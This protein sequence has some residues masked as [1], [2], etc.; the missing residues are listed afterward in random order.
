MS[1][2]DARSEDGIRAAFDEAR[3]DLLQ[4]SAIA[5]GVLLVAHLMPKSP[6]GRPFRL[7]LTIAYFGALLQLCWALNQ[8]L[9]RYLNARFALLY[10]GAPIM[11]QRSWQ[12]FVTSVSRAGRILSWVAMVFVAL[13]ALSVLQYWAPS[14]RALSFLT[15][16][17]WWL[18]LAAIGLFPV[19][20]RGLIVES[21]ER[22]RALEDNRGL[23]AFKPQDVESSAVPSDEPPVLVVDETSFRAGGVDWHWE[24][25]YTSC[26]VFGQP[27][28]GKTVC[29]L[30]ALLD[31]LLSS[32]AK[33]RLPA[34]GLILDP[35]GDFRDKISRLMERIGRS[36]DL[37]VLDPGNPEQSARWNPLDSP[38]DEMELAERLA[39]TMQALGRGTSGNESFWIDNAKRFLRHAIRLIRVT[40][41]GAPPSFVDIEEMASSDS[42]IRRR[43]LAIDPGDRIAISAIRYF[44]REWFALASNTRSSIS[45]QLT[46]LLDPFLVEPYSSFFAGESTVSPDALL[47]EGKVL[48]VYMPVADRE[49]MSRTVCTL[50]KLEFFREVLRNPTKKR[51]SLFLCDEFQQ[52]MT[53]SQGRGDADFFERSRQSRHAN[54]IAT[55]N[56]PALLK[57]ARAAGA[58]EE[59]VE[60]LVGNCA[61]KLFLRN[62]DA[63]TNEFASALFGR[64][65]VAKI[66]TSRS[67]DRF[68]LGGQTLGRQDDYDQAVGPEEFARLSTPNRRE[69]VAY[70]E[71]IGLLGSRSAY[72]RTAMRWRVH[73]L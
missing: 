55:Q 45:A 15:G 10:N 51:D 44:M 38:D 41:E 21:Y 14:L 56:Y 35:K 40:N 9:Q 72:E 71:A 32:S 28:S 50:I 25:F 17:L 7:I 22:W 46:T 70:A 29:V 67:Q 69:G 24:D 33:G 34:S 48:Y 59:V 27:G 23:S 12:Q 60:N 61:L 62:T 8:P 19:Y 26:I 20:G 6:D 57:A 3:S 47:R 65:L 37:L 16:G 52:F 18:S 30:N 68:A 42:A 64:S 63:K 4:P 13:T 43:I 66:S 5:A 49:A 58:A 53:T 73:P 39:A 54:I 36:D 11:L 1:V 31:G 2:V